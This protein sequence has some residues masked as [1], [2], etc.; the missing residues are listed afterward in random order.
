MSTGIDP[1]GNCQVGRTRVLFIAKLAIA[2][3]AERVFSTLMR[4]ISRSVF[5]PH[6]ATFSLDAYKED[7]PKDLIIHQL[8]GS[9]LRWAIPR[10]VSLVRRVR[11]HVILSTLTETNVAI[12]LSKPF[13]PSATKVIVREA[14]NPTHV[15]DHIL[16]YSFAWKQAY[17]YL[18]PHADAVVCLSRSMQE[19]ALRYM[20]IA[21]DR[22][23]IIYNGVDEEFLQ[24][25]IA[26]GSP[27][28]KNGPNLIAAGRLN[29]EKNFSMLLAAFVFI[30]QAYPEA[31]LTILG[32]GPEEANLKR[33][34]QER[35]VDD[36]VEFAGFQ[37]NPFPYYRYADLYLQASI[38][39]G[40]PNV[41]L[42]VLSLGTPAV[43][44]IAGGCTRE[45]A[46]IAGGVTLVSEPG[47]KSYSEAVT[48]ALRE[49]SPALRRE[50]FI[51][52]FGVNS[53]IKNY[54]NLLERVVGQI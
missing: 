30:R 24:S 22:A 1:G 32:T 33:M 35:K 50:H 9:E 34:A 36:A 54:E 44:T 29:A 40:L 17:R 8:P 18:Y 16:P 25:R 53:M 19:D 2:G 43:A 26:G 45:I 14:S 10:M 42:E 3:G 13:F 31:Q 12:L 49:G 28:K 20:P 5:E 41:L 52:S 48:R 27:F 47:P 11:P 7:I 15:M 23:P 38:F 4:R 6:L 51:Q 37:K 46:E 21:A 39:E